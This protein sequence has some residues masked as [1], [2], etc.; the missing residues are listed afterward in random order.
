[1][2]SDAFN[3]WLMT[4]V[5]PPLVMGIINL[6]PDSFS[7]GG[8]LAGLDAAAA[9]A[10]Q[11]EQAGADWLDVGGESTRPGALPIAPAEQIRRTIAA[12]AEIRRQTATLIS[13]DTTSSEVARAALDAGANVVNDISAGRDDPAMFPLVAER[14]VPIILMHMQGTPQ[15]MHLSPVYADVTAEVSAFL[16]DRRD[17]AVASGVNLDKILFDP[18][19]GFG[20][21]APHDLQL[22]RDTSA[23]AALGSP[24]VVG[25]SRKRFIG[26][27]TGEERPDR[28]LFGT[29]AV[30]AWCVANGAAVVR[31]HDVGPISQVV[32]VVQ[33]IISQKKERIS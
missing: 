17:Q 18:G 9:Y 7:D 1:M 15:T 13:I 30:V 6:T 29:A 3:Q 12:I 14:G 8:R 23:L 2:T 28:R 27:I 26:H 16:T 11:L 4:P 24:L 33:A 19:I 31:V 25:P 10:Q 32:R 21:N 22:V 20:K 5:R